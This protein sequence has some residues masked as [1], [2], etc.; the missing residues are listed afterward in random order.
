MKEGNCMGMS[1]KKCTSKPSAH[2][3]EG[4]GMKKN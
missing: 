2:I 4:S 1:G 3:F